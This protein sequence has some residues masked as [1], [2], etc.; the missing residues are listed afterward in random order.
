MKLFKGIIIFNIIMAFFITCSPAPEIPEKVEV[1]KNVKF[2]GSYTKT[3]IDYFL[4]FIEE[5]RKAIQNKDA[6]KCFSFYSKSFMSDAGV[7]LN[8]LKKNTKLLYKAYKEINYEVSDMKVHVDK[9][10]AVTTDE[11]IYTAKPANKEYKPLKYTGKERIY[12][13]KEGNKWKIVNW[14]YE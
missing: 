13:Q 5:M 4:V 3:D 11:Y 6:E 10:N 1:V 12:W 7:N 2:K 8:D 9:D 14:I